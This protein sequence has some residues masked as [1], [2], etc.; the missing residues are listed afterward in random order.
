MATCY[1][2]AF[3]LRVQYCICNHESTHVGA[4]FNIAREMGTMPTRDNR[5]KKSHAKCMAW[6]SWNP[7]PV[8][9]AMGN[10]AGLNELQC[11]AGGMWLCC[12]LDWIL[13]GNRAA[14]KL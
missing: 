13:G 5:N 14:M 10:D 6:L 8:D 4:M 11:L 7:F 9:L 12:W 2:G 1:Q 3:P